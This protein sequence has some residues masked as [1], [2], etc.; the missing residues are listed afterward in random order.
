MFSKLPGLCLFLFPLLTAC[1][2]PE[3]SGA[4]GSASAPAAASSATVMEMTLGAAEA[5]AHLLAITRGVMAATMKEGP[6]GDTLP[7]DDEQPTKKLPDSVKP[8]PASADDVKGK[9]YTSTPADW[10]AWSAIG[11]RLKQ[12][13][14]CQYEWI[15]EKD[16]TGTAS[17]KCDFDGDGKLDLH[18]T[19]EVT[20]VDDAPKV[21]PINDIISLQK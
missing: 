16:T 17:A 9:V 18:A 8:V 5:K 19:Q 3:A 4:A 14:K 20:I 13:Q 11:F 2:K 15:R 6:V 12:P 1:D 7:M 10:E 21:A